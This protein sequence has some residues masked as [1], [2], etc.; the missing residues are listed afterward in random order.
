[1]FTNDEKNTLRVV[2]R[3]AAVFAVVVIA[4]FMAS[5]GFGGSKGGGE[6]NEE[7]TFPEVEAQLPDGAVFDEGET[8]ELS[9]DEPVAEFSNGVVV[10][11]GEQGLYTDGTM[12][13]RETENDKSGQLQV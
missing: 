5:C 11:F 4:T 10:D 2:R 6:D 9:A 7:V 3:F 13:V 1:M 8:V 12:S